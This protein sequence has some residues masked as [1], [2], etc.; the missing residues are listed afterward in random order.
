[1]ETEIR[2]IMMA[3]VGRIK[4][5]I[6]LK[7]TRQIASLLNRIPLWIFDRP[8][9]PEDI[10][11]RF[12]QLSDDAEEMEFL[13]LKVIAF[14]KNGFRASL[15]ADTQVVWTNEKTWEEE[16]IDVVMHLG[17]IHKDSVWVPDYLGFNL[18]QPSRAMNHVASSL[19][20]IG[21]PPESYDDS[22]ANTTYFGMASASP[23]MAYPI[24][25]VGS[26]FKATALESGLETH[27]SADMIPIYVPES[28]LI[29]IMKKVNVAQKQKTER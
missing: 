7:D 10:V 25:G 18:Q 15:S 5:C 16:E 29:E 19:A 23:F 11:E 4:T 28:V 1:M 3:L 14:E 13:V 8:G 26:P 20:G 24:Q 21:N 12:V 6:E 27:S 9:S 22:V 17:I 2:D